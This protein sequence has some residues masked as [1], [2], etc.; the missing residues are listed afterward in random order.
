MNEREIKK[1]RKKWFRG[2]KK[3]MRLFIK[4]TQF[5]YLDQPIEE[6]AIV[7][8]NHVGTGAPLAWELYSKL[9][10]RF[11]GAYEMNSG[12]VKLY[13]YQTRVYYHEKKHWN[14]HLARLFCLLASPLTNLFY[15][16]LNLISTYPDG[17]FK[18]T[19][20][21]SIDALEKGMNV[22]IFPEDSTKGYLDELEGFHLGFTALAK[23]CLKKGI[24]APL[25]VAYYRKKEKKYVVDKPVKLS[26]LFSGGATREEVAAKL[27]ARCN[28]LGKMDL[29]ALQKDETPQKEVAATEISKNEEIEK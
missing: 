4:P 23:L 14:L 12:L 3:V 9:P 27:C 5:I 11:W 20:T 15:K 18:K 28:E 29:N 10:L 22:I 7:L 17:R 16:G 24:D 8:S 26:E 1:T 19:L 6:G 13:K 21:Q 25:Y 2:V